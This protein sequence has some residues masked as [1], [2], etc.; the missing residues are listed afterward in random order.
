MKAMILAAG[1][2]TR[3]RP[4]TLSRPKPLFPVL[5]QPLILR[6]LGQ[7]RAAGFRSIVVNAF[8]LADQ[9]VAL[10]AA[11]SDVILQREPVELGTGGG[12]RMAR[13]HFGTEPVLVT[14]GDIYHDIDYGAVM[15]HHRCGDS[16]ITMVMHDYP[17]FNK[18]AVGH[19]RVLCFDQEPSSAVGLQSLAFAGIHVI[20]PTVLDAI[21]D[22]HFYSIIDRYKDHLRL[23]G[24]I[25]AMTVTGHF[26]QDMGTL[27][28]YLG[29]HQFLLAG[30]EPSC[31]FGE[32]V[33]VGT[34]V[35]VADWGYIGAGASIGNGSRLARVVVWDGAVVPPGSRLAD[36]LVA[37]V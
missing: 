29:L 8:H 11:Q 35:E 9:V 28:D 12:L 34:E 2:G 13:G 33:A 10:L 14:N 15:A 24:Q 5:G 23:G 3:L 21:P 16:P 1:L 18:V 20:D 7:L 26:W 6:I 27:D 30:R 32:G 4:Y 19:G 25:A 37:D 17:R 22:S 31:A 36:C